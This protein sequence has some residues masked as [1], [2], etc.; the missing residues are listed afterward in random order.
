MTLY[1]SSVLGGKKRKMNLI[2]KFYTDLE[3][4]V[5]NFTK[6]PNR[7]GMPYSSKEEENG[8]REEEDDD[9]WEDDEDELEVI[10]TNEQP[11]EQ[12]KKFYAIMQ[13]S[14][15]FG[16][17]DMEVIDVAL[18]EMCIKNG[19]LGLS[20]RELDRA[21]VPGLKSGKLQKLKTRL[22]C[23][24]NKAQSP[25]KGNFS[26]DSL[27]KRNVMDM[28]EKSS[29]LKELDDA[30]IISFRILSLSANI[31]DSLEVRLDVTGGEWTTWSCMRQ[32]ISEDKTWYLF[33]PTDGIGFI[34]PEKIPVYRY[35]LDRTKLW[36]I[37]V[38]GK[39][40]DYFQKYVHYIHGD[41]NILLKKN[42]E[43]SAILLGLIESNLPIDWINKLKIIAAT[44]DRNYY[45]MSKASGGSPKKRETTNIFF[46]LQTFSFSKKKDEFKRIMDYVEPYLKMCNL[47][48]L[49]LSIRK[50]DQTPMFANGETKIEII[51]EAE[52]CF[53][54]FKGKSDPKS[55]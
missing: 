37:Y 18:M 10:V 16:S 8:R 33:P 23:T 44:S 26:Q 47:W 43:T 4:T 39:S 54:V 1:I 22:L 5:G 27:F 34:L 35:G 48:N 25:A 6:S 51:M 13:K 38:A 29:K 3:N 15:T 7:P 40:K 42:V 36:S 31:P 45:K 52:F 2:K 53:S 20:L 14:E 19:K 55:P 12:Q 9:D 17:E 46:Y 50:F 24:E 11:T 41:D 32:T 21:F 28:F 49:T 30:W